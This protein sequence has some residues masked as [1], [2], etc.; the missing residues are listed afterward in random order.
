MAVWTVF[1]TARAANVVTVSGITAEAGE[2]VELSVGLRTD[3]AGVVA[4][5][6]RLPLPAGCTVV[7]GSLTA[8]PLRL[9]DH[10]VTADVNDAGEYVLVVYNTSLR[11]IAAGDGEIVRFGVELSCSPGTYTL[12]PQA[13]LSNAAGQPL[14]VGT[15]AAELTV[16]GARMML[17]ENVL[18]FYRVPIRSTFETGV[19][20]ANTG[21]AP[22]V[23]KDFSTSV[24]GLSVYIPGGSVAPGGEGT[25]MLSYTPQNRGRINEM[26]RIETND[27]FEPT[28]LL[29]IEA[30]AYSVNE[31]VCGDISGVID[32]E[33]TVEVMMNNMDPIVG[34]DFSFELPE[35]IEFVEGSL[36]KSSRASSL[37]FD[38]NVVKESGSGDFDDWG[39]PFWGFYPTQ[40][41]RIVGFSADNSPILGSE[42][43]IVTFRLRLGTRASCQLIAANVILANAGGENLASES[44]GGFL[45][46]ATPSLGCDRETMAGNIADS[47]DLSFGIPVNNYGDAPLIIDRLVSDDGR[48]RCTAS[49]PLTIE[50]W[51]SGELPMAIADTSV[52]DFASLLKIY[53]NDPDRRCFDMIVRGSVYSPNELTFRGYR[54]NGTFMLDAWLENE[55]EIVALQLD[56]VCSGG[57]TTDES[58][59]SLGQRASGHSATLARVA[60]DRYRIVMFSI[61]NQPFVGHEGTVFTLG[62]EGT[63]I[64]GG[65][66]G[67]ENIILSSAD[68]HN[69][70][71]PDSDVKTETVPPLAESLA[72]IHEVIDAAP[73]EQVQL[74]AEILPA[75]AAW[76]KLRWTSSDENVATVDANGLVSVLAEGKAVIT[77]STTDGSMLT[78]SCT[79]GHISGIEGVTTDCDSTFTV[80]SL[81]GVLI[82]RNASASGLHS[83]PH[84]IYIV[85]GV[86]TKI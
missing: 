15:S 73:G 23:L 85:N 53:S 2:H 34:A 26:L 62:F 76:Q 68:G 18:N 45:N 40:V 21:T 30:E 46:V 39:N 52:G 67:I 57:L 82:L 31:L 25:L 10:S 56:L 84:G 43:P 38:A 1:L 83:L 77:V 32:Q 70:T 29:R 14:P 11:P 58:K 80:Y 81:Q 79:T 44:Q 42:G 47:G 72:I 75:E 3:D 28:R 24:D 12:T 71:T 49:L 54:S 66:V 22:L 65:T 74:K 50:P 48:L 13:T 9:P 60:P 69:Y 55:A 36:Q 41:L 78:A 20:I 5:E 16:R 27:A 51:Q 64:D 63:D 19:T 86:K 33:V 61:S 7:P 8:N 17:S 4:A 59:L 35:G 37:T 6:I